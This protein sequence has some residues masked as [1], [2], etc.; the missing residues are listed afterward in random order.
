MLGRLRRDAIGS[1][2]S[3]CRTRTRTILIGAAVAASPPSA[4]IAVMVRFERTRAL[5]ADI[6]RLSRAERRQFRAELVEV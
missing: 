3:A 2:G 5:D 1:H 6:T 4:S